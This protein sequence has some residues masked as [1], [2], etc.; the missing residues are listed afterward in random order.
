MLVTTSQKGSKL[1]DDTLHLMYKDVNLQM[2]SY[3]KIL[4]VF[5][6]KKNLVISYKFYY[7]KDF[8]VLMATFQNKG[9]FINRKQG[10]IL[11][12]IYSTSLRFL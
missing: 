8:F 6:E 11:Q 3:D 12:I 10:Q 7:K 5:V 1:N 4:G 2:I 9:I